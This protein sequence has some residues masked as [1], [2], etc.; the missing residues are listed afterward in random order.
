[1]TATLLDTGV[2]VAMLD[3]DDPHH[4]A[5]K[6]LIGKDKGPLIVPSAVLPEVCYL[7]HKYLGPASEL[8]FT[9][10]LAKEELPVDWAGPEDL[11]RAAEIMKKRPDLGFVDAM[12]I[13]AAE[14][15]DV[16]RIGTLDRRH[17]GGF[18]PKHCQAFELLP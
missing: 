16:R 1:M 3:R 7:A 5:A 9:A 2:L 18:R 13:A 17:F 4:A 14:R 11:G 12:V 10:S 6:D 8:A 15:L